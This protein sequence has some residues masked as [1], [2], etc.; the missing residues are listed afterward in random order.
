MPI[1]LLNV[2]WIVCLQH[3]C[4]L[5]L[6]QHRRPLL[7]PAHSHAWQDSKECVFPRNVYISQR[8]AV[9]SMPNVSGKPLYI[10]SLGKC[11]HHAWSDSPECHWNSLLFFGDSSSST[12]SLSLWPRDLNFP[13]ENV[14][15]NHLFSD[16][17]NREVYKCQNDG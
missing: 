4:F 10:H 5:R 3:C 1:P 6:A 17:V 2:P 14:D 16:S 9:S 15:S 13:G 11:I 12:C 7:K 8:I